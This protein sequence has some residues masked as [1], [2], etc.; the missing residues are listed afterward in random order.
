MATSMTQ[1]VAGMRRG[2]DET[3]RRFEEAFNSGD[4][5]RAAR[6]VYTEDARILPPGAAMVEGRDGI[7]QFWTA[8]QQGGLERVELSTVLLEPVGEQAYEVG[9]AGAHPR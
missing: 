5:A 3:N 9:R 6:E 7:A 2:I 8:A 1:D 4:P